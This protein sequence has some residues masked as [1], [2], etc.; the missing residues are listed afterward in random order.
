ME[1]D[2]FFYLDTERLISDVDAYY[3]VESVGDMEVSSSGEII[4]VTFPSI[5]FLTLTDTS[6]PTYR[7]F[8]SIYDPDLFKCADGCEVDLFYYESADSIFLSFFTKTDSSLY[9]FK[10]ENVLHPLPDGSS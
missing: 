4:A 6:H 7:V 10:F 9:L 8:S 2:F 5:L 3:V 1:L